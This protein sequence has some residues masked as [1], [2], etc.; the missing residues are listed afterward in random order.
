MEDKFS[1]Q[2]LVTSQS[3]SAI[4]RDILKIILDDDKQYTLSRAKRDISK[5]KGGINK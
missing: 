4:E 3:F 2:A 1:K 5:F